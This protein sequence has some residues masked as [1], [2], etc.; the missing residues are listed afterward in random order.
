MLLIMVSIIVS[1]NHET[2]E[3]I[4]IQPEELIKQMQKIKVT[5]MDNALFCDVEYNKATGKITKYDIQEKDLDF[6]VIPST[7]ETGVQSRGDLYFIECSKPIYKDSKGNK[8]N[9]TSCTKK[10]ECGELVKDCLDAGGCATVCKSTIIL[11]ESIDEAQPG[12]I[13]VTV[14]E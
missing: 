13:L 3:I 14:Q 9:E 11:I 12:E 10:L 2:T 6:I 7:L 1:C 8:T 4:G 5:N